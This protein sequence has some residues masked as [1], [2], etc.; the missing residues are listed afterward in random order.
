[1]GFP[2][3]SGGK[4]STSMWQTW[5]FCFHKTTSRRGWWSGKTMGSGVRWTC[6]QT[7]AVPPT[8][9][10]PFSRSPNLSESQLSWLGN[11]K[12]VKNQWAHC[13]CVPSSS[14]I[15][16]CFDSCRPFSNPIWNLGAYSPHYMGNCPV[17]DP[18]SWAPL[19]SRTECRLL[20]GQKGS[21][22]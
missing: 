14:Q 2:G 19:C 22:I 15:P 13:L 7:L 5:V 3:G 9:C 18:H 1:M 4:E 11:G 6:T 12:K 8:S 16:R 17:R 10:A 21:Q 20:V